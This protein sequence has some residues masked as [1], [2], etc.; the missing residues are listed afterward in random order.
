MDKAVNER[1]R[2]IR[3]PQ[4]FTNLKN[5]KEGDAVTL[6]ELELHRPEGFLKH[7]NSMEKYQ[8]LEE[9]LAGYGLKQGCISYEGCSEL[10]KTQKKPEPLKACAS[11]S[12][13]LKEYLMLFEAEQ[14]KNEYR[15]SKESGIEEQVDEVIRYICGE[16][17]NGY[18]DIGMTPYAI[19]ALASLIEAR[20]K[21]EDSNLMHMSE[22]KSIQ[23]P[24]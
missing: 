6:R 22:G 12:N 13:R 10:I 14:A 3:M 17:K 18:V 20:A 2:V 5:P 21:L 7:L 24:Y 16:I 19:R 1:E 11:T 4:Y 15:D 8:L 9:Q 23:N